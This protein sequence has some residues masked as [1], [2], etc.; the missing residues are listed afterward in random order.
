M[1][2]ETIPPGTIMRGQYRIE[3]ALG[4]GGFGHVYLAVDLRTNQPCAVKEY[5]V[6]GASGQAQLQHEARVLS[7]LHHPH[8][9]SFIDAFSERGRYYVVLSYIEGRDLTEQLRLARQHDE[10]I[11]LPVILGWLLAVCD[12]VQF[13]H[14]QQPPVIHRDIKPDNIRIT[15]DGTAYLVDLGNAKAVADGARTLFFARHQGTPGYAPPEQYPGGSGTDPRSDVYALGGTLYFALTMQEPAS[16]SARNQ[17]LQQGHSGLPSLQEQLARLLAEEKAG[18]SFRFEAARPTRGTRMPR[19]VAQLAMLPPEILQRLNAIIQRAMALKPTERYQSVAEFKAELRQVL[20]QL[21][22]AR[23]EPSAPTAERGRAVD[24][25]KTQ[26]D[27]PQLYEDLHQARTSTPGVS[28]PVCQMP[29]AS[30]QT[31]CPRCG[32]TSLQAPGGPARS[33]RS[34]SQASQE[35]PQRLVLPSTRVQ[36]A[37]SAPVVSDARGQGGLTRTRRRPSP[38]STAPSPSTHAAQSQ[39]WPLS[40]P[41]KGLSLRTAIV[42]TAIALAVLLLVFV[43]LFLIASAHSAGSLPPPLPGA[44]FLPTLPLLPPNR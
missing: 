16:V 10:A 13:L 34:G 5:L 1:M 15:S 35:Q 26:P 28:C 23:Q 41:E 33:A 37:S 21:Q 3:R 36:A 31:G 27:L 4:S 44:L 12:A 42:L 2:I 24:P 32:W 7:R 38:A 43:F 39:G 22:S 30:S 25:H 6:T 8:L 19:H 9:P 17:A 40:L 18:K 11:P 29:L 20:E 14:S